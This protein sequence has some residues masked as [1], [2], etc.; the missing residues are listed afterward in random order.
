[1]N[2]LWLW[3]LILKS[4]LNP[5]NKRHEL[6]AGEAM[7][8]AADVAARIM[9]QERH[10]LRANK[11][12]DLFT[13]QT[14][15]SIELQFLWGVFREVASKYP[16]L[17]T[18]WYNRTKIHL[19][20]YLVNSR[21]FSFDDA[22]DAANSIDPLWNEDDKLFAAIS[23]LG[24]QAYWGDQPGGLSLAFNILHETGMRAHAYRADPATLDNN[25]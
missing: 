20:H 4:S 2:R 12:D 5:S 24:K 1:M 22:R 6:M 8:H 17:P 11:L 10:V 25:Q 16:E 14:M 9:S 13:D 7:H 19:I 18:D 15:L 3:F 23:D 21:E